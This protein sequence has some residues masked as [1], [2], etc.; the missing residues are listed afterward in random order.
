MNTL[1]V[2]LVTALAC[3]TT[4]VNAVTF[5]NNATVI[6]NGEWVQMTVSKDWK[7]KFFIV[8]FNAG[9]ERVEFSL[10][11]ANGA[12]HLNAY[13]LRDGGDE[14]FEMTLAKFHSLL[15]NNELVMGL[16]VERMAHMSF[17]LDEEND[18]AHNSQY[19]IIISAL[20]DNSD[21]TFSLHYT[22]DSTPMQSSQQSANIVFHQDP[23]SPYKHREFKLNLAQ[24]EHNDV[25]EVALFPFS[26]STSLSIREGALSSDVVANVQK[27]FYN[28]FEKIRFV[29][30]DTGNSEQYITFDFDVINSGFFLLSHSLVRAYADE[31]REFADINFPATHII[32][33]HKDNP[34]E[35][36]FKASAL[37]TGEDATF[38][39]ES[40]ECTFH[41]ATATNQPTN[42][43]HGRIPVEA[44]VEY[45]LEIEVISFANAN[46]VNDYCACKVTTASTAIASAAHENVVYETAFTDGVT[47]Q[48]YTFPFIFTDD[49]DLLV[50]RADISDGMN[51]LLT[52]TTSNSFM[53]TQNSYNLI[54][55]SEL[56]FSRNGNAKHCLI[57]QLC[58]LN[59]KAY[60][61]NA[62]PHNGKMNIEIVMSNHFL[63]QHLQYDKL[64]Y[65][66]SFIPTM[67][68]YSYINANANATVKLNA[69]VR[70]EVKHIFISELSELTKGNIIKR[71][72][73]PAED[74]RAFPLSER[75]VL[76]NNSNDAC[77][78]LFQVTTIS[79]DNAEPLEYIDVTLRT[80]VNDVISIP[81]NYT[82][83]SVYKLSQEQTFSVVLPAAVR[84]FYVNAQ[85]AHSEFY[86]SD[87]NDTSPCCGD[88][89]NRAYAS[90][91]ML[92]F[93]VD[94]NLVNSDYSV[95]LRITA[96]KINS[97]DSP[98]LEE[99][100]LAV[101]T[102]MRSDNSGK[103]PINHMKL[104]TV[105]ETTTATENKKAYLLYER[106]K[107]LSLNKLCVYCYV[108]TNTYDKVG[109]YLR[110]VDAIASATA[111]ENVSW[112][113]E[114]PTKEGSDTLIGS[115]GY[116][117]STLNIQ[118]ST[119]TALDLNPIEY[120]LIS[121][122]TSSAQVPVQCGITETISK[123]V[124]VLSQHKQMYSFD[125][126]AFE[127]PSFVKAE[128]TLSEYDVYVVIQKVYNEIYVTYK[129]ERIRLITN[130]ELRYDAT[131]IND[132]LIIDTLKPS[133]YIVIYYELRRKNAVR[134]LPNLKLV[135]NTVHLNFK[136]PHA[137]II[138][139][140]ANQ[141]GGDVSVNIK[142][143][144]FR[145]D[146]SEHWYYPFDN[147]QIRTYALDPSAT[148]VAL[149]KGAVM[150]ITALISE[151]DVCDVNA[152]QYMQ[153]ILLSTKRANVSYLC[154]ELVD[155][156]ITNDMISDS[157]YMTVSIGKR[158]A[159]NT[160]I[161]GKYA[162]DYLDGVN[163]EKTY[164]LYSDTLDFDKLQFD[165]SESAANAISFEF[166]KTKDI[167]YNPDELSS[168]E[169]Y[170]D[171]SVVKTDYNYKVAVAMGKNALAVVD[172]V[173]LL[174]IKYNSTYTSSDKVFFIFKFFSQRAKYVFPAIAFEVENVAAVYNAK[175][176]KV[177]SSW[178]K[179]TDKVEG[180]IA[181]SMN[182]PNYY[183]LH[184]DRNDVADGKENTLCVVGSP[185]LVNATQ[186][187]D[188]VI[189]QVKSG[190]DHVVKVYA[191]GVYAEPVVSG[192]N[193][194]QEY[195][196]STTKTTM[197]EG[198]GYKVMWEVF[199]YVYVVLAV[200]GL[201]WFG[202][203][204]IRYGENGLIKNVFIE[205]DNRSEKLSEIDGIIN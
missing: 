172:S 78:V 163:K 150:N 118:T 171:I 181:L 14:V 131:S 28:S 79:D 126:I 83:H 141:S 1:A 97:V 154:V 204:K 151:S 203:R 200:V 29:K 134:V 178:S 3:A 148:A 49:S 88:A 115:K 33:V 90:S 58:T 92:V 41:I 10:H 48:Q 122:N 190:F 145:D 63:L 119:G 183:Y 130:C 179:I 17:Q 64:L 70:G 102:Y 67:Y 127:L 138:D 198:N 100:S 176:E 96:R 159:V 72:A 143:N 66:H 21:N 19:I 113:D 18:I 110:T 43:F 161:E 182:K 114:Y 191:Y 71:F 85:G 24:Y 109:F 25:I 186:Q 156:A 36:R 77:V 80:N 23:L 32:H 52:C 12:A 205:E 65:Y 4:A 146:S 61:I 42:S 108:P 59:I 136:L 87:V 69:N 106:N 155:T 166:I 132:Q 57:N 194:Y 177:Q 60:A 120:V 195:L 6:N 45:R 62:V 128:S 20:S 139:N 111:D 199:L 174:H 116:Y 75:D 44:F 98:A 93:D 39:I 137:F 91:S 74:T 165:V 13:H 46:R 124:F 26:G 147:L 153:T 53:Q 82:V 192:Y 185:K 133:T 162:V 142:L 202:Y 15:E 30:N 140:T 99:I 84:Q 157:Y 76:I 107:Q 168:Y 16:E 5:A 170:S 187:T 104:N 55:T 38:H 149:A 189:G 164:F 173:V 50:V 101:F 167:V 37:P 89:V 169:R 94:D 193:E 73:E 121:V 135:S 160:P 152:F 86:I 129:N 47:F 175:Q 105:I 8:Q 117:I 196:V 180:S 81:L 34:S 112:Y 184:Y 7:E 56:V 31:G 201:V 11:N 51:V 188:A 54:K 22:S 158:N 35:L 9:A 2:M 40:E 123:R 95:N 103:G 197:R 144:S 27:V 68:F 125:T